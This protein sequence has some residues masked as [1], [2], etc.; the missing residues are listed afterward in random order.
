[1]VLVELPDEQVKELM[2]S[3]DLDR[4][5]EFIVDLEAL[6]GHDPGRQGAALRVRRVDALPAPERSR[7]HRH[8]AAARADEI[9]AYETVTIGTSHVSTRRRPAGD[10]IGPEV[11][12]EAIRVLDALGIEHSEHAFGGNAILAQ[13][14]AA[15]GRDARRLP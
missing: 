4:G 1:M 2:E 8:H 15:P 9:T 11:A 12:A 7:R 10:G 14:N 6:D 3:V 13:G 5:S